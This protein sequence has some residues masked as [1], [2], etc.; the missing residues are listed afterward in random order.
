LLGAIRDGKM[1]KW[2]DDI[3]LAIIEDQFI[4][5]KNII[6][7]ICIKEDN[8]YISKKYNIK[9]SFHYSNNVVKNL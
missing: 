6:N 7:K 1:I 4:K 2:D 8:Y 3:D 9:F 5:L